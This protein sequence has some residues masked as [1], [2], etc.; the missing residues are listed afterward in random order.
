MKTQNRQANV[1]FNDLRV[2]EIPAGTHMVMIEEIKDGYMC[3]RLTPQSK[4]KTFSAHPG[5]A[6]N[7]LESLLRA[8][9]REFATGVSMNDLSDLCQAHVGEPIYIEV[10]ERDP[11]NDVM[12]FT[13]IN[14][15]LDHYLET[16]ENPFLGV[17]IAG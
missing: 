13:S 7:K 4:I 1:L 11:F 5:M 3:F 6:A 17:G 9:G 2:E 12:S 8:N 15:R 14:R 16:T 10:P